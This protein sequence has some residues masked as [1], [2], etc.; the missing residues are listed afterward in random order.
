M[1][2]PL[3]F[4]PS[5]Q[6]TPMSTQVKQQCRNIRSQKFP[7]EQCKYTT[8]KGEFCKRHKK[9]PQRYEV[10]RPLVTRAVATSIKKIQRW[11]KN[12][13]NRLLLKEKSP[14]F[15]IRS[16]CHNN[17]ELSSLGPLTEV[18]RD[19]FFVLRDK[20]RVWGF[21]IRTLVT[22][23]EIEGHLENPYTKE[24]CTPE[25][26]NHFKKS[27]DILRKWKKPIQYEAATGLTTVQN[28]NLR[29]LDLCLNFDMLGYRIATQWFSDLDILGHRRL[30]IYLFQTW[31]EGVGLSLTEKERIVPKYSAIENK[32]FKWSPE[33]VVSKNDIDS[34][35][36]T[37]LN[38]MERL[39]SSA[40][41][42][43]DKTLGAMYSVMALARVSYRCRLAY[44][45]LAD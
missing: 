27:V 19:Y 12:I 23:Y 45:W 32:L 4:P 10:N 13:H 44:P 39:I 8:D 36:R 20:G 18:P 14:A 30:Y 34:I 22:Q 2:S 41:E 24:L 25:M 9:N 16:L 35:R 11:W 38:V 3:F 6:K 26:V 33:K 43:S 17:S 1:P 40:G 29:V 21:D 7:T 42:Q 28:W 37:N 31:N 5:E 15:F